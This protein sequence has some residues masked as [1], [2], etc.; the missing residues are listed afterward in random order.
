MTKIQRALSYL[1]G[2]RRRRR[3]YKAEDDSDDSS[4]VTTA[5]SSLG[6]SLTTT[7]AEYSGLPVARRWRLP[8]LPSIARRRRERFIIEDYP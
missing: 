6:L 1:L 5:T 7:E 2:P 4:S 8:K 3:E